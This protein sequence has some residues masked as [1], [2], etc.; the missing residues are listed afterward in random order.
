MLFRSKH[1]SNVNEIKKISRSDNEI[2]QYLLTYLPKKNNKQL[3]QFLNTLS[4][5]LSLS[6]LTA[7][8]KQTSIFFWILK[9]KPELIPHILEL[10]TREDIQEASLL[11]RNGLNAIA[12]ILISKP[13]QHYYSLID[14]LDVGAITL[15]LTDFAIEHDVSL[16]FYIMSHKDEQ[17]SLKIIEKIDADYFCLMAEETHHNKLNIFHIAISKN[18]SEIYIDKMVEKLDKDF[19][20]SLMIQSDNMNCIPLSY[21]CEDSRSFPLPPLNVSKSINKAGQYILK[22]IPIDTLKIIVSHLS[23]VQKG[24]EYS[25]LDIAATFNPG[26][27]NAVLHHLTEKGTEE[28]FNAALVVTN[29]LDEKNAN[30]FFKIN[31]DFSGREIESA[32]C[33]PHHNRFL[34]KIA[35]L[36]YDNK[37]TRV[38]QTAIHN[39]KEEVTELSNT[40]N[41]LQN[42]IPAVLA[43]IVLNYLPI[44]S[45][46]LNKAVT[47]SKNEPGYLVKNYNALKVYFNREKNPL[48]QSVDIPL[49]IVEYLASSV[50]AANIADMIVQ[51]YEKSILEKQLNSN[52]LFHFNFNKNEVEKKSSIKNIINNY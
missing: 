13:S 8:M 33:T 1:R 25:V 35:R 47:L 31:R 29:R 11:M 41:L 45:Q 6:V 49:I 34:K 37:E 15:S 10:S 19:F 23:S 50:G 18:R 16:N 36:P 32:Q 12:T 5:K 46:Q 44:M 30:Y 14:Q 38:Y 48:K 26:F 42:Y 51:F 22:Y 21:A 4:G 27:Y 24:E 17:L 2:I 43:N 52:H 7:E 9:H 40:Y 28:D 3:C 20:L 39:A